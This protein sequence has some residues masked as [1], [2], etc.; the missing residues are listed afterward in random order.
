MDVGRGGTFQGPE[1]GKT[2][3]V[4]LNYSPFPLLLRPRGPPAP[5]NL[6]KVSVIIGGSWSVGA[7]SRQIYSAT[8]FHEICSFSSSSSSSLAPGSSAWWPLMTPLTQI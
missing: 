2:V 1:S 8:P 6:P 7:G 5:G 3:S 4:S